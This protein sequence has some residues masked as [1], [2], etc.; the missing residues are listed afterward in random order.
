ML[1]FVCDDKMVALIEK[2]EGNQIYLSQEANNTGDG[3]NYAF[4]YL[5]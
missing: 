1:W 2:I 5:Q 3:V 4:R